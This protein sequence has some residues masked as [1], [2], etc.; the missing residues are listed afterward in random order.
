MVS[1]ASEK[2]TN[3]KTKTNKRKKRSHL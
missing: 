3:V 2:A 1:A